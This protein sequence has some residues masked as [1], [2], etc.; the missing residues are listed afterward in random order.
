[1]AER[2]SRH[3]GLA[4]VGRTPEFLKC[5]EF[6]CVPHPLVTEHLIRNDKFCRCRNTPV[7]YLLILQRNIIGVRS[8]TSQSAAVALK[9]QLVCNRPPSW[10]MVRT[11]PPPQDRRIHVC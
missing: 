6:G 10:R 11:T 3:R 2:S 5:E 8:A 4:V 7:R 9:R 1:M